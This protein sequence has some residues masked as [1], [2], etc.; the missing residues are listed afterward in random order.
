MYTK[1]IV[2]TGKDIPKRIYKKILDFDEE[3]FNKENTDF[4]VDTSMPRNILNSFLNKNISTTSIIYNNNSKKVV[5]YLQAFPLKHELV[6]D[7]KYGEKSFK[8]ITSNDIEYYSPNKPLCLYIYSIGVAKKYRGKLLNFNIGNYPSGQKM[9]NI[10]INEFINKLK[11]LET[12]N[13]IIDSILCEGVSKKGQEFAMKATGG[14]ILFN[15]ND[16][17]TM[18]CYSKFDINNFLNK[19]KKSIF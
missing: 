14:Q 12:N 17:G 15:N 2:L 10:L 4:K 7:L 19:N 8:D 16:I 1:F 9:I 13:I 3:I 5:A 6:E 11:Q 18:M